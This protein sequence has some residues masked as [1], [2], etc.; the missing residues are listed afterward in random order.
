M[1]HRAR[2][3]SA[4]AVTFALAGACG[5]EPQAESSG[6]SETSG[7][8]DGDPSGDGD[9]DPSGDGDGDGS[10][11]GDG[12]STGDGD[13]DPSGG[14]DGDGPECG[15]AVVDP[16]EECDDGQANADD[17]PCTLACTEAVCGD[18]LVYAGVEE[19]DDG[20][21]DNSDACVEGCVAASCSDGF[22]FE[23]SES[24]VD[25]GGELCEACEIGLACVGAS[26][27]VTD[28]CDEDGVC[29]PA[30]SWARVT[31][32]NEGD[33]ELVDWQ[34]P[35]DLDPMNFV[36]ADAAPGGVDLRASS[37][38]VGVDL[39]HWIERWEA[40]GE[41]RVWL[42]VPLIPA[43]GSVDVYLL[44]GDPELEDASDGDAVFE[45]FDDHEDG[46]YTDKWSSSEGVA[47]AS[48]QDGALSVAGD[49]AWG[50]LATLSSFDF[51][52]QV[53]NDQIAGGERA[54]L[55]IA[56]DD[57]D[58]RYTFIDG[59]LSDTGTI[60]Y[61]QI[62]GNASFEDGSFPGVFLTIGQLRR[63]TC[64]LRL[65]GDQ[66][67]ILEYCDDEECSGSQLF[68]QAP[69]SGLRV[70]L[71]AVSVNLGAVTSE[72]LF[73]TKYTEATVTAAVE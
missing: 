66:V 26:D 8:G 6:T 55:V 73:V 70:G 7:D 14:G 24:D 5:D 37:D 12:D 20:N 2:L 31:I 52:L 56:D 33:E 53:H 25:C 59:Q 36:Y 34:V 68:E 13:G 1:T 38:G 41:S 63:V 16:G 9:G 27:C 10:G 71:S 23:G 51:P 18:G 60:W 62:Y 46:D 39:P 17:G 15:D 44:Y 40:Q 43:N 32:S 54:G 48:E 57:S 67:E 72:L 49:T 64:A 42:R 69:F 29:S 65:V 58:L 30:G 21:E 19:C 28:F 50:Y 3:T 4:L 35:V 45:F 11:D 47:L 61:D 22:L